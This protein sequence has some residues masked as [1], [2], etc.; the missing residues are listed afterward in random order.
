MKIQF[1]YGATKG[2]FASAIMA[3]ALNAGK[4]LR[5]NHP[6]V[7]FE[8]ASWIEFLHIVWSACAECSRDS[9]GQEIVKRLPI[10]INYGGKAFYTKVWFDSETKGLRYA[11]LN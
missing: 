2:A 5:I 1:V 4:V 7:S 3:A 10:T 6:F 8:V 11:S 9:R